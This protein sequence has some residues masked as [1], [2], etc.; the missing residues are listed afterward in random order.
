VSQEARSSPPIHKPSESGNKKIKNERTV[1]QRVRI[2]SSPPGTTGT[3]KQKMQKLKDVN[4]RDNGN[5][6]RN[7][8]R[9]DALVPESSIDC[10]AGAQERLASE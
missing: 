4:R 8:E 1:K 2:T 6:N 3:R 5:Q 7:R 10:N 9:G